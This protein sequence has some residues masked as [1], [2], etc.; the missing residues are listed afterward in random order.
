MYNLSGYTLADLYHAHLI[1]YDSYWHGW[2]DIDLYCLKSHIQSLYIMLS[3]RESDRHTMR[4]PRRAAK[5]IDAWFEECETQEAIDFAMLVWSLEKDI[6]YTDKLAR[7][8]LCK[9]FDKTFG[10]TK[11]ATLYNFT[12]SV[13][14]L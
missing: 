12:L 8:R 1:T 10:F 13:D 9:L 4:L 14:N 6:K 2:K 11:S 7:L 3:M 5:R